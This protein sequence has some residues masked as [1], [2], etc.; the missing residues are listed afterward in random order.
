MQKKDK[1]L[2]LRY[3]P[4]Y[5][6]V[7]TYRFVN[8]PKIHRPIWWVCLLAGPKS[9]TVLK[10]DVHGIEKDQNTSGLS[11]SRHPGSDMGVWGVS[12][13]VSPADRPVLG[14]HLITNVGRYTRD[15]KAGGS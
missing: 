2:L 6:V 4:I 5:V 12:D 3:P 8:D 7:G 10:L 9:T 14:L 15:V 11:A 13:A 1:S